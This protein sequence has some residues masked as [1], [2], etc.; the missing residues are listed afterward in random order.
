MKKKYILKKISFVLLTSLFFRQ[1]VFAGNEKLQNLAVAIVDDV[2]VMEESTAVKDIQA[3]IEAKRAEYQKEISKQED[4]LRKKNE[5]LMTEQKKL[6]AQEFEEKR[7]K[8]EE[9]VEKVRAFVDMLRQ[10]L[11]TAY[12]ESLKKVQDVFITTVTRL[13]KEKGGNGAVPRKLFIVIE[14]LDITTEVIAALN[15]ELPK[16]PVAFPPQKALSKVGNDSSSQKSSLVKR[17]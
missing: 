8:F 16:L 14:G 7:K 10:T 15:K 4:V 3:Q 1:D 13:V 2:K 17:K 9:E 12:A 11:E 5:V 6:S